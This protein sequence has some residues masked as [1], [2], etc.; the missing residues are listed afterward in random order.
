MAESLCV[1]RGVTVGVETF[2]RVLVIFIANSLLLVDSFV[3]LTWLLFSMIIIVWVCLKEYPVNNKQPVVMG[4][5]TPTFPYTLL[6][7]HIFCVHYSFTPHAL[8]MCFI[9]THV[10]CLGCLLIII[11]TIL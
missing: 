1:V 5:T 10:H 9:H 8:E 4:W 11:I 3:H 2:R 6:P 7:P